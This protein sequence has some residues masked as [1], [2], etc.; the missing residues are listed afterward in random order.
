MKSAD[1]HFSQ[2]LYILLSAS[3]Q[4]DSL[5]IGDYILL[6]DVLLGCYLSVEGILIEEL[7]ATDSVSS[8]HDCIFC[9]HL[10]RQY[11]SSRELNAFLES[12]GMDI[13][14]ITDE[15][16]K[17]YLQALEVISQSLFLFLFV[18]IVNGNICFSREAATMR[19]N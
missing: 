3:I 11:S 8:L 5:K 2:S 14:K 12:Y 9:V 15:S 4:T 10:Q 16:E 17:K 13:S 18:K 1:S 19:T 6:R 7:L